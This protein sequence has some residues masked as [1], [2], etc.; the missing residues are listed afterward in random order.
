[1]P[2][3]VIKSMQTFARLL[4]GALEMVDNVLTRVPAEGAAPRTVLNDLEKAKTKAEARFDSMDESYAIQSSSGELAE[5]IEKAYTKV[6][7]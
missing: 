2:K 6:Y 1:M 7:N 5:D 3:D 4:D